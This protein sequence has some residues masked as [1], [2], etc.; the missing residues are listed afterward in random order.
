MCGLR[1]LVTGGA[2]FIGSNLVDRLL[3][4]CEVTVF[5]N[6]Y[7]GKRDNLISHLK[8]K[9]FSLVQGDVRKYK[10]VRK[11]LEGVDVVFHLA[12]VVSV[13]LSV[14]KPLFVNEVNLKGTLNV[15][16]ACVKCGV[17][18]LVYASTCAVYGEP[19][20]LPLTEEH[21]TEPK[22]PYAVSKLAAE[23][24]C[25]VFSDLYGLETVCLRF[26]NVYGPRQTGDS[27]AGVISQFVDRL[28]KGEPP[29]IYGDGEQTRDFV[30]VSDVVEAC[31]LALKCRVNE[32]AAV[33]M[34]LFGRSDMKPL[35][36][37]PRNGDI[38]YSFADI[39][40]ARKLLGY[41]PKITLKEGLKLL[42]KNKLK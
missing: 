7:S 4:G 22:S 34:K 17:R 28:Q 40:K 39:T 42:L 32:L 1:V 13:P 2:G 38:R 37:K 21:P 30:Y 33:M 9:R 12:A 41:K 3:D 16:N 19:K 25:R 31:M 6:F 29:I 8:D 35:H 11:A 15:L 10:D 14:E 24:Y 20:F 26:F 36:V 5:D 23:H 18:R 27:Y